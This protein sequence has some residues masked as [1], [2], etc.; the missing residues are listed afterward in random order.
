MNQICRMM[1]TAK[2]GATIQH[3]RNPDP[4]I[5]VPRY[6]EEVDVVVAELPQ[7]DRAILSF[8]YQRD[9]NRKTLKRKSPVLH[10]ALLRAEAKVYASLGAFRHMP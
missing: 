6:I 2:L 1:H 8:A 4:E 3:G 10:R 9:I 5:H 7:R